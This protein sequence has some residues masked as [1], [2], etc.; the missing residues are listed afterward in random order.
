M[1]CIYTILSI[2]G[3]IGSGKSTLLENLRKHYE[4]NDAV[5]FL[6]EPVD[7]W[8][9]ITDENGETILK[10]FQEEDPEFVELHGAEKIKYYSGSAVVGCV[11][12]VKIFNHLKNIPAEL[13]LESVEFYD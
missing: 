12:D 13:V 10:K 5:V 7:E 2:E 6:K 3:N 11:D 4:N 9:K 8:E 1:S